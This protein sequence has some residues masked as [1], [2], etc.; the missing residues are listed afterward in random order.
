M[1]GRHRG[2]L[3]WS[4]S[5]SNFNGLPD[6]WRFGFG[7]RQLNVNT[8]YTLSGVAILENQTASTENQDHQ[9][10]HI[11]NTRRSRRRNFRLILAR[12]PA[13]NQWQRW[14]RLVMELEFVA[15]NQTLRIACRSR[16]LQAHYQEPRRH[17]D[18]IVE[19]HELRPR[20]SM[21][22][23]NIFSRPCRRRTPSA[24]GSCSR[25]TF[26]TNWRTGSCSCCC[27]GTRRKRDGA[28]LP[29]FAASQND[30]HRYILKNPCGAVV[31]LQ[32]PN[33]HECRLNAA[34]AC[35]QPG[36]ANVGPSG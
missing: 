36:F 10:A 15:D 33:N 30:R 1:S 13:R 20:R 29:R 21:S 11:L 34:S 4:G 31:S 19:D 18:S 28:R 17:P 5:A 23:S 24:T 22:W 26:R 8:A 25:S 6:D 12:L 35:S 2:Y 27:R 14:P 7:L 9:P 3:A 32:K 16:I